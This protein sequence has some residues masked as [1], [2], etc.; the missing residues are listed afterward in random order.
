MLEIQRIIN[1]QF[2]RQG[3]GE[4]LRDYSRLKTASVSANERT[5]IDRGIGSIRIFREQFSRAGSAD[6][7]SHREL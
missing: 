6:L 4:I 1:V 3:V 7:S 5:V 2:P